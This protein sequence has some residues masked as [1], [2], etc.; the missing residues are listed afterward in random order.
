MTIWPLH[1]IIP[2]IRSASNRVFT[3]PLPG[4]LVFTEDHTPLRL[5]H[6]HVIERRRWVDPRDQARIEVT[7]PRDEIVFV[8]APID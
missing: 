3:R 1:E 2:W 4:E 5:V 7:I 6:R 8:S